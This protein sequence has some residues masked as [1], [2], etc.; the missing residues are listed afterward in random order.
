M[1]GGAREKS[2]MQATV[3]MLIV[4]GIKTQEGGNTWVESHERL[5][6]QWILILVGLKCYLAKT[7][8]NIC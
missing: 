6:D 2:Q 4:H 1:S 8:E 3:P 5:G 7:L